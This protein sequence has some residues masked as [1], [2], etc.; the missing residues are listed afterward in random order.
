M[1]RQ[2]QVIDQ[3]TASLSE[4]D[5]QKYNQ[6]SYVE[7]YHY[8]AQHNLLEHDTESESELCFSDSESDS[9]DSESDSE[10]SESTDFEDYLRDLQRSHPNT[11]SETEGRNPYSLVSDTKSESE[12]SK[13]T[14]PLDAKVVCARPKAA[15]DAN[16]VCKIFN[17]H[18]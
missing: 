6:L 12:L 13:G 8:L 3:H 14:V 1:Q 18:C 4:Q 5:R 11:K 16:K 10:D 2:Q 7:N 17:I 9:E 15:D